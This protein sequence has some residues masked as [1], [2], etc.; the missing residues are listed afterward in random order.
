MAREKTVETNLKEKVENAGGWCLKL[1]PFWVKGLPDRM[2]LMPKRKIYFVETKVK[3]KKPSA[4]QRY[5][6]KKLRKLGFEVFVID[7]NEQVNIFIKY[8]DAIRAI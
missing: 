3:G 8:I 5:I 4:I 1:A 6:H 2:V 7:C